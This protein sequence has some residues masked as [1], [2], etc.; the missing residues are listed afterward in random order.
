MK[1]LI[2]GVWLLAAGCSGFAQ[3]VVGDGYLTGCPFSKGDSVTKVKAFY[4][5]DKEPSRMATVTPGQAAYQYHFTEYGVWVFFDASLQVSTIRV[6]APFKGAV[7][8]VAVGATA[9]ELKRQKGE[10]A[11][12]FQ[13]FLDAEDT[14]Q[15]KEKKQQAIEAL[16]D[17][18]PKAKVRELIDDFARIDSSPPVWNSAWYY[19]QSGTNNWVRYDVSP[20]SS[21]VTIV[22]ASGCSPT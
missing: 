3:T 8:G 18:V 11:R 6:E 19:G 4:Q 9:E 7:G 14:K 15:R 17:Q 2:A 13:G 21:R 16:S 1:K 5:T 10:P 20:V 22:L 12:V